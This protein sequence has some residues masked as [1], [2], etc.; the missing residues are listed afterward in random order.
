VGENPNLN[1]EIQAF[2]ALTPEISGWLRDSV[3]EW[4]TVIASEDPTEFTNLM[5]RCRQTLDG[6]NG[7]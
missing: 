3:D 1:Y 2:N 4:A 7:T 6:F 5:T